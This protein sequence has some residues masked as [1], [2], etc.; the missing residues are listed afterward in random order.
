M[1]NYLSKVQHSRY[2]R[3]PLARITGLFSLAKRQMRASTTSMAATLLRQTINLNQFN[4]LQ[5]NPS[6]LLTKL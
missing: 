6:A 2:H 4:R 1:L 3:T 5:S